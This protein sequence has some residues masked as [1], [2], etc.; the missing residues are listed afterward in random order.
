MKEE[1]QG[2]LVRGHPG[3][4]A[5][6]RARFGF[7]FSAACRVGQRADCARERRGSDLGLRDVGSASAAPR[8]LLCE[9]APSESTAWVRMCMCVC[10]GAAQEGRRATDQSNKINKY[11]LISRRVRK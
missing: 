9:A 5:D 4:V 1:A 11:S 8:A 3:A 7:A 2:E 6:D 10:V